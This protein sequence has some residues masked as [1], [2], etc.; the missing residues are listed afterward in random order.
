MR[1]AADLEA[2]RAAMREKFARGNPNRKLTL[3]QE[4]HARWLRSR[5]F[6]FDEIAKYFG[7]SQTGAMEIVRRK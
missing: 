5:G 7:I 6:T 1:S 4:S 2:R 3:Q